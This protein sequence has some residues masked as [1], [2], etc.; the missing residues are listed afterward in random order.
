MYRYT[1][2]GRS[3]PGIPARDLTDDEAEEIGIFKLLRSGLYVREGGRK[4][5]F[6]VTH[7]ETAKRSGDEPEEA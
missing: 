2:E 5:H 4:R 6:L 1:G 7:E 3:V